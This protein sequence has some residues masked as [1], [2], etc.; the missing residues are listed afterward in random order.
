MNQIRL[1]FERHGQELSEDTRSM[2]VMVEQL[3]HELEERDVTIQQLEDGQVPIVSSAV[4]EQVSE[5]VDV[6]TLLVQKENEV[7]NLS[8]QVTDLQNVILEL[9]ENLK[10]KDCVIEAR[11]QAISLLSEDMS[12]KCKFQKQ[13]I[14]NVSICIVIY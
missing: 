2:E 13:F 7:K 10:E 12:K 6:S 3:R 11:T 1:R 4:K 9:Q 14:F 5:P 8:S